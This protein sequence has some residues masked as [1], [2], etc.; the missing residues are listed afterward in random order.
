[1][2]LTQYNSKKKGERVQ[3]E[4][5]NKK[6]AEISENISEIMRRLGNVK[7]QI[8]YLNRGVVPKAPRVSLSVAE[9]CDRVVAFYDRKQRP[10]SWVTCYRSLGCFRFTDVAFRKQVLHEVLKSKSVVK[11]PNYKALTLCAPPFTA[12][13]QV[14]N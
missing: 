10:V 7:K 1:V 11:V 14:E 12:K 13:S 9:C 8:K 3:D 2:T 4:K 5:T 6:L